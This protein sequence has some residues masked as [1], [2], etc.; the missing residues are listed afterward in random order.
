M[1]RNI[2]ALLGALRDTAHVLEKSED[3]Q[4][5]HMGCC[6]CGFLAQR[7]THL[8]KD[9]IHSYAMQRY[10]DWS[11]QLND[12][13]PTSGMPIDD[14]ISEMINFGFDRDDLKNLERLSDKRILDSMPADERY[15][16]FNVKNDVIKYLNVWASLLE[17]EY[18][19]EITL[20]D[21]YVHQ[22]A[23]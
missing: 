7:I 2:S 22:E 5:G 19:A 8:R 15:L 17:E 6:N 11:E 12:Y 14:L 10:G 21:L 3:Y 1:A 16:R 9:K 4:W 13:C 18:A 23:G 20:S